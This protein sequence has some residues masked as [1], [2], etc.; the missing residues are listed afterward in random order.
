MV[1]REELDSGALKD[2]LEPSDYNT[3]CLVSF[4]T[5]PHLSTTQFSVDFYSSKYLCKISRFSRFGNRSSVT[6]RGIVRT[7]IT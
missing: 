2:K 4:P 5:Y 7:D 3:S 6:I 1:T